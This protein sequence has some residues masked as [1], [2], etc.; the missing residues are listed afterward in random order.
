MTDGRQDWGLEIVAYVNGDPRYR[1]RHLESNRCLVGPAS[2]PV[3]MSGC[4]SQ[5]ADQ[6]WAFQ[7]RYSS[8]VDHLP[9]YWL[10]NKA[11]GK[12]LVMNFSR[13]TQVFMFPCAD[14]KD[15]YFLAPGST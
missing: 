8:P 6:V 12:C 3:R 9:Y 11:T 2:G 1:V 15:Q 10:R 5:Y 7:Y 4:A 14:Y 13:A